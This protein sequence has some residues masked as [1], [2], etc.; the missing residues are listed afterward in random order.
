MNSVDDTMTN[1]QPDANENTRLLAA[2]GES[3]CV[4]TRATD[5]QKDH[6]SVSSPTIAVL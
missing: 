1:I 2:N 6:T 4:Q 5:Y 3:V